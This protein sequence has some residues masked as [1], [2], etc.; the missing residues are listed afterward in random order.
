MPMIEGRSR[1][2]IRTE[3]RHTGV[4]E[5]LILLKAPCSFMPYT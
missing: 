2:G 4:A 1:V 5:D 3:A